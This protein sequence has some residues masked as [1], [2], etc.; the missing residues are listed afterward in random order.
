MLTLSG[1]Q[2]QAVEQLKRFKVGALF[3]EP[4]TGKTFTACQLLKE[5]KTLKIWFTTC[6]NKNNL[7]SELE[8]CGEYNYLI[9]GIESIS[10]S[11]R[12]YNEIVDLVL[13][14]VCCIVC[15]ESIKI[16]NIEAKRT[17]RLLEIS[18]HCEY[19][20]ILNGTPFTKSILDLWTQMEFL[21]PKI[22][23]MGYSEFKNKFCEYIKINKYKNGIISAK[24]F[25]VGYHNLDYLHSLVKHYI[26][27]C[28]LEL[29]VEKNQYNI[30][31]KIE[32]ELI[33][34]YNN[35]KKKFLNEE[36]LFSRD[37]NIFLELTQKMQHSY[38][39]AEEKFNC[40]KRI[41]EE[42][43]SVLIFCKYVKS[44][45]ELSKRFPEAVVLTYGRHSFGLNLQDYNVII[46]FDKTFDYGQKL[47]SSYRIYRLGQKE[48]CLYYE[49]TGDVGLES[50]IDKNITKKISMTEYFKVKTL[51]ELQAEL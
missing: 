21:S 7:Q 34:E 33:E 22:L 20:L 24:E 48:N 10:Q 4:G 17:K 41:I 5:I 42:H 11:D 16:K 39:C 23:N 8:L 37:G 45:E 28:K 31:Y 51:T 9:Y 36:Y 25:I 15:D 26:Y 46:Y 44:Q 30:N 32:D 18:K 6:A 19:K 47:Q 3:M 13:S 40:V 43:K 49:L 2:L 27:E 50:V 38:C 1:R 29:I 35:I 14:K 12:I